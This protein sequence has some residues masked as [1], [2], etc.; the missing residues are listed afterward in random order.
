[1]VEISLFM[2]VKLF[3]FYGFITAH[4]IRED[5]DYSCVSVPTFACL[6]L[7]FKV[8]KKEAR[9]LRTEGQQ[10]ALQD[11][12]GHGEGQQQGPQLF[13]AQQTLQTEDL[14]TK[15]H[16]RVWTSSSSEKHKVL[17]STSKSVVC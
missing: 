15:D 9:A 13:R 5:L 4:N 7:L 6:L 8:N 11:G 14:N 17:I 12:G 10:D 1:M 16:K 2:S 3:F